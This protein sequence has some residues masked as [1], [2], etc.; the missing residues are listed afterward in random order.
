MK[1][2]FFNASSKG[3]MH[4]GIAFRNYLN[5]KTQAEDF[6]NYWNKSPM[7]HQNTDILS[8]FPEKVYSLYK[9]IGELSTKYANPPENIP[10]DI[11]LGSIETRARKVKYDLEK[12]L[13]K[14]E[15]ALKNMAY[16]K[17][18][19]EEDIQYF[20]KSLN[21]IKNNQMIFEK[22]LKEHSID[23][24]HSFVPFITKVVDSNDQTFFHFKKIMF[25]LLSRPTPI[26]DYQNERAIEPLRIKSC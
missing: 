2:I 19:L 8:A 3:G 21:E 20:M 10:Y 17:E 9:T 4:W 25:D 18:N 14:A 11:F 24:R 16:F 1:D 12:E 7:L 23:R 22:S 5:L 6:Y 15:I 26:M 13:K